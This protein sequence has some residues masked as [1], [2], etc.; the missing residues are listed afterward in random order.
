MTSPEPTTK[1]WLQSLIE[2][3]QLLAW[4]MTYYARVCLEAVFRRGEL[5]APLLQTTKLRDEAFGRFWVDFSS[6]RPDPSAASAPSPATGTSTGTG[7][8][9]NSTDLIPSILA[10]ASG[11]VLDV[12]PGTGTQMPLLRGPAITAL[13]GA[14]PCAGLHAALRARADEEGLAGKYTVLP[15]GAAAAELVPEL[16]RVGLVADEQGGVPEGG[17]FDTIICVRVLCSVAEVEKTVGELYALLR[18]GGKM[19]VVEHV[20]NPWRTA[21]GSVL[22]R[23]MQAVYMALG[24]GLFIGDCCLDRDTERVLRG[25]AR[26]DGGWESVELDRWFG[27]SPLAYISGVLVKKKSA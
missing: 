1:Q 6:N 2:P 7:P 12:G 4:A 20:V 3:G 5:L 18:P 16:R 14:E 22:A 23:V 9:Q 8:I 17:V 25:A 26:A 11:V 13:Y 10:Q 27:R 19:L 24:W 21:K 15:C